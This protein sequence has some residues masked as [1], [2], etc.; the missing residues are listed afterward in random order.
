M[1]AAINFETL[2]SSIAVENDYDIRIYAKEEISNQ[3]GIE[4]SDLI[5]KSVRGHDD[6]KYKEFCEK[7]SCVE[8]L[9]L[10]NITNMILTVDK[11]RRKKKV[12]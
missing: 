5:E 7:V 9:T 4:I 11:I 12:I 8:S 6:K 10:E 2:V 3:L 1:K